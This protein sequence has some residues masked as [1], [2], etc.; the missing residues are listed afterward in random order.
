MIQEELKKILLKQKVIWILGIGILIQSIFVLHAGYDS[1]I[2][3]DSNIE[4]YNEYIC[5]YSGKLTADKVKEYEIE[6][7]NIDFVL[8]DITELDQQKKNN[9][10]SKEYYTTQRLIY[11]KRLNNAQIFDVI[12]SKYNYSLE[13]VDNRYIMDER[14]WETILSNNNP[15][16]VYILFIIISTSILFNIEY[17]VG[18][19]LLELSM[20]NGK[21]VLFNIKVV[22]AILLMSVSTLIYSFLELVIMNSLVGLKGASY[23]LQSLR[24]FESS[25]YNISIIAAFFLVCVL[26]LFGGFLLIAFIAVFSSMMR[27]TIPVAV[28][29]LILIYFPYFLIRHQDILYRIPL[30][31]GLLCSEGILL[32][33]QFDYRK[34]IDGI[35][36]KVMIFQ[37]MKPIE[38]VYVVSC[39]LVIA[40]V[41]LWIARKKY[42]CVS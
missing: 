39:C 31:T 2:M 18:M 10:I 33:S 22:V 17:E 23:P 36:E 34:S 42:I 40:L 16:I 21:K 28:L 12:S 3:I 32:G 13:D 24:Y 19:H 37:A 30:P 6:E 38:L 35:M 14:G 27:N 41:L 5:K 1:E 7:V 29:S 11:I 15:D 9:Q 8:K 25:E 4:G 20:I 26:R